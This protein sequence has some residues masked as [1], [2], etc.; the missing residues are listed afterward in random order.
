[1]RTLEAGLAVCY[2]HL[3]LGAEYGAAGAIGVDVGLRTALT[4]RLS[5]GA[6]ATNLFRSELAGREP[7]PR[8]LTIGLAYAVSDR[9]TVATDVEQVVRAPARVAVGVEARV[10][11]PL[12]VRAGAGN[13]PQQLALGF[14]VEAGRLS[15]AAAFARHEALGWTPA[16]EFTI[17]F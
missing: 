17:G 6:L 1:T 3:T 4:E 13:G 2:D 8:R 7:L 11:G 15:V 12:T 14:G 5:G 10:A 9:V 16:V